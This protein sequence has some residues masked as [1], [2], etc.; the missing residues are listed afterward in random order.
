M[1]R[2]LLAAIGGITLVSG[3]AVA[4]GVKLPRPDVPEDLVLPRSEVT[5]L[6]STMSFIE[7]GSGAPVLFLHGNPTSAYLW[8]NVL[9]IVGEGHRALAVDLIG[10]GASGKPDIAYTFDDHA[11]YLDAFIDAMGWES[12]VLVGHDWGATLAWDFA[13]RHPERV[14]A[15]AFMEG[16]L[17]PAFPLP[18][19]EAI[20]EAGAALKALRTPQTGEA[21]VFE[22]NMFV[23]QMLPGF[24][25]RTLGAKAMAAYRAP[26]ENPSDRLPTLQWP[27]ELPIAGVPEQN[28]QVMDRIAG[29]MTGS[30]M[31]KL[32]IYV[33]P[34]VA[35]LAQA[36]GWYKSNLPE[37]ETAFVGQGLH[38]F[39]EDHPRAIG[40]AIQDWLRRN[41]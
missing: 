36:V 29:H 28:V 1:F 17:P 14:R 10:M 19:Y 11:R 27:R 34:G 21:M 30:D 7:S 2:K 35:T 4:E 16:V 15:I 32:L 9:P 26:F 31:P 6:D 20:G 24:V 23:E 40:L 8:R 39:Q 22:Q 13:A 37:L 25:N 33:E 41:Q 3:L 38:F 18:S 12:V 5:V